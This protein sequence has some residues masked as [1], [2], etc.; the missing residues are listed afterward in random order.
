MPLLPSYVLLF[1]SFDQVGA[2]KSSIDNRSPATFPHL[3]N[4]PARRFI[5]DERAAQIDKDN[6]TLLTLMQSHHKKSSNSN[7]N[8]PLKARKSPGKAART[9]KLDHIARENRAL[10]SRIQKAKAGAGVFLTWA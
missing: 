8:V 3:Q 7:A 5:K 4:S 2:V 9:L 10:L 1:L 6:K